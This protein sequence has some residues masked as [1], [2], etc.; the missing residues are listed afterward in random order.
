MGVLP[1]WICTCEALV[2]DI[3]NSDCDIQFVLSSKTMLKQIVLQANGPFDSFFS[4]DGTYNLTDTGFPTINVGTVD[5]NHH[6]K[7][8]GLCVNRHENRLSF[9]C[10]FTNIIINDAL[11]KIFGFVFC[12]V[13]SCPD[14]AMA[15]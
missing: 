10:V 15:I 8:V 3:E 5:S 7:R 12:P 6:F 9:E 13:Y 2:Q 14:S 11:L 4:T 1:G